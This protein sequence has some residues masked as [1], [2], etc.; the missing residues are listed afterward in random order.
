M[1]RDEI[2]PWIFSGSR[3]ADG[4][5]GGALSTGQTASL[6]GLRQQT[7]PF[8]TNINLTNASASVA[9]QVLVTL[10]ASTVSMKR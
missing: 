1:T 9:A 4:V 2:P 7:N 10:Y 6:L 3:F 8:R 5:S